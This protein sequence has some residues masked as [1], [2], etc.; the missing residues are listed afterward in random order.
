MNLQKCMQELC[1]LK[2]KDQEIDN[3]FKRIGQESVNSDIVP[4][5]EW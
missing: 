2:E 3:R 1:I 5:I 4:M